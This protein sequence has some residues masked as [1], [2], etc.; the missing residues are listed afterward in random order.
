MLGRLD[1]VETSRLRLASDDIPPA[2]DENGTD[3]PDCH[4]D[5]PLLNLSRSGRLRSLHPVVCRL[6]FPLIVEHRRSRSD[7]NSALEAISHVSSQ[8]QA[9]ASSGCK[10]AP[11]TTDR[12]PVYPAVDGVT[13]GRSA[14][15]SMSGDPRELRQAVLAPAPVRLFSYSAPA[16]TT[17]DPSLSVR[18]WS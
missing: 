15:E 5:S 4:E 16:K 2:C 17:S 14:L 13:P 12:P 11:R 3:A 8:G 7:W 1:V 9:R 6:V 18:H 10:C